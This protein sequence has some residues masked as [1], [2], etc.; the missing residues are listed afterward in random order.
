[1]G[2]LVIDLRDTQLPSGDVP[3][4]VDLGIGSA[5]VLV[6]EDVRGHRRRDRNG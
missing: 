1:M 6:A 4:E 2:E 3:V 5:R